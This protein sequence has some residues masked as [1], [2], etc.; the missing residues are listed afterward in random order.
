MKISYIISVLSVMSIVA[1][2]VIPDHGFMSSPIESTIVLGKNT[3]NSPSPTPLDMKLSD[4]SIE[5]RSSALNVLLETKISEVE[6]KWD[7]I[8]NRSSSQSETSYRI[9]KNQEN[10]EL[11]VAITSYP[12]TKQA[13]TLFDKSKEIGWVPVNYGGKVIDDFGDDGAYLRPHDPQSKVA[14]LS[15]YIGRFNVNITGVPTDTQ[16]FAMH[17]ESVLRTHLRTDESK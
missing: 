8:K 3:M 7:L 11:M 15:F 5:Q 14:S 4:R 2:A 1:V 9:W 12:T 6:T 13:K 16:R 17:I 10:K